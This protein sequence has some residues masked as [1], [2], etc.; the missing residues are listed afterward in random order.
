MQPQTEN[1]DRVSKWTEFLEM[2]KNADRIMQPILC[3]QACSVLDGRITSEELADEANRNILP[4]IRQFAKDVVGSRAGTAA[5]RV[6]TITIDRIR[7]PFG[8]AERGEEA[9]ADNAS[10]YW[11]RFYAE[12]ADRKK[13]KSTDWWDQK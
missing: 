13:P 10:L 7:C 5:A 1:S 12:K 4:Q 6:T 11:R 9:L 8:T 3:I 2:L